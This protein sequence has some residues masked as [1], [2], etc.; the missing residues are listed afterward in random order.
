M[1]KKYLKYIP[2][3]LQEDFIDNRVIPL[4]GAGFSKNAIL[5]SGEK[6]L[7]WEEMG[8]VVS[9]YIQNY[10]YTN[11]IDALSLFES[12]FSRAK[13]IELM[14]RELKINE[15]KPGNAHRNLCDI[16]FDTICTTNFDFLIEQALN[17]RSIPFSTI[18]S[19]DRL[20]ISTHEKTK[21]IKLHGDFNHPDKMVITENDYDTFVDRNKILSTYVSNLFIT[22]T[23]LL[24]GYS[25]EDSDMRSI[26]N[27]I[28]SRLGKLSSPAYVIL[29]DASPI[30][31]ARFDRR[32]IKVIN[33][34]GN[35][36]N[37]A[38]ILT[39]LFAEIKELISERMPKQAIFTSE[40]ATE[41]LR[42]PTKDNRLCFVSAPF[43]R[44]SFLKELLYPT[45]KSNGISPITLDETIMQGEIL[46]RKID[47]LISQSSIAIVD[48]SGNNAD[49]MWE[50]GTLM[51]KNKQVVLIQDKNQPREIPTNL[52]GMRYFVYSMT[53][54]NTEF[55]SSLS[56][57][58]EEMSSMSNYN[59]NP[60]DPHRL[61]SM[62]EYT[63]A[64]ILS[65]RS[66]ETTLENRFGAGKSVSTMNMVNLLNTNDPTQKK[67]LMDVKKYRNV[68]NSLVHTNASISRR[69]ATD[70][71]NSVDE[72]CKAINDGDIIML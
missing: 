19:E 57:Y 2:K 67:L 26:W 38:E 25:F 23:L 51:D 10:S 47:M 60:D 24:I 32:S 50:L 28:G 59:K 41:E 29:V 21:L 65:F 72:L 54:D 40:K 71:V 69:E 17:E 68:R 35:K 64:V 31:I 12:E 3:S 62:K 53:G 16:Y 37:Y 36:A 33:I 11:P 5:P 8:K 34:K 55:I 58:F 52:M 22:K 66:L 30:E 13:L 18:V 70:I 14:A 9:T 27:I 20:P 63:A 15:V 4:I 49:V 42:M 43:D 39:E 48:L 6:M 46:T 45:L 1:N 44:I 7:D 56:G 61:L